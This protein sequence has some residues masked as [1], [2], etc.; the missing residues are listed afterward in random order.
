MPDY[1]IPRPDS[2]D[3]V[4]GEAVEPLTSAYAEAAGTPDAEEK[5]LRSFTPGQRLL[6]AWYMYWDDVTNGGHAQYFENYTGNLWEEAVRACD[7]FGAAEAPLLREAIALFPQGKPASSFE[8]RREQLE[9]ID[10]KK[11]NKLD[12]RFYKLPA[13]DDNVLAYMDQHAD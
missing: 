4:L 12:A 2:A 9:E 8:E 3:D 7:V 1:R 6:C 11:F 10:E 13:S 5:V